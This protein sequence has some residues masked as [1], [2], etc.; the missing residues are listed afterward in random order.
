ME[1]MSYIGVGLSAL[2]MLGG[3]VS[4]FLSLRIRHDILENNERIE[5][6][7]TTLR[8]KLHTSINALREE[9]VREFGASVS[10]LDDRIARNEHSL[11]DSSIALND[12]ILNTVNGKYVRTDLYQQSL[13]NIQE[14]FTAMKELIEMN[15]DKI[16]QGLD[17]QIDDLKERMIR[18]NK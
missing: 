10:K 15:M 3:F 12:K 6:D 5:K 7:M 4:Y 11:S 1:L 14:R 9:L 13:S 8:D 18:L 16:E 2:G 17:R